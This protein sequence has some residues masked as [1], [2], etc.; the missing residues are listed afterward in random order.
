ML[1]SQPYTPNIVQPQLRELRL[2]GVGIGEGLTLTLQLQLSQPVLVSS[3]KFVIHVLDSERIASA[4]QATQMDITRCVP[5]GW[6]PVSWQCGGCILCG[7]LG[8]GLVLR[9]VHL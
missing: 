4:L 9:C 6:A 2:L 8:S 7:R 1:G 5:R 3:F